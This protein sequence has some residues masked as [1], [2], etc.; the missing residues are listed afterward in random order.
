M[1]SMPRSVGDDSAAAQAFVSS[2]L[3]LAA[4][5]FLVRPVALFN[6]LPLLL[7]TE[8]LAHPVSGLQL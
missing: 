4:A 6:C 5:A 3:P 2:M 1:C 8:V 7:T